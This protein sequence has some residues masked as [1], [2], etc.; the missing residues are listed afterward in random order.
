M[1]TLWDDGRLPAFARLEERLLADV[2]VVGGGMAGI[3]T[4]FALRRNGVRVV[5]LEE[6]RLM[7]GVS[8]AATARI[9]AQHGLF[10]KLE[11]V[12]D[13]HLLFASHQAHEDACAAEVAGHMH[14]RDRHKPDARIFDVLQND[15]ADFLLH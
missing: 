14:P 1:N 13:R 2:A 9:S 12:E 3:L 8:A 5:L 10:C 7:G 4:A 15:L 11:A 6:G